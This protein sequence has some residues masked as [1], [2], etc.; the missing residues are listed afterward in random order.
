[1]RSKRKGGRFCVFCEVFNG[2]SLSCVGD[3]DD[4]LVWAARHFE[5]ADVDELEVEAELEVKGT[6]ELEVELEVELVRA[7]ATVDDVAVVCDWE[8][9]GCGELGPDRGVVKGDW[10]LDRGEFEL[11]DGADTESVAVS[12]FFAGGR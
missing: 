8:R 3:D 1:M 12:T 6:L 5:A 9:L 4:R 7:G 11:D 2:I 10:G